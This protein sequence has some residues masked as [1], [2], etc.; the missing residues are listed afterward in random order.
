VSASNL[1]EHLA[2][3][4]NLTLLVRL[5]VDPAGH[6]VH[7]ELVELDGASRGSFRAWETLVQ[8]LEARAGALD[9]R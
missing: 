9:E 7:G 3:N 5:V 1:G 2:D 4:R 6:L 8:L